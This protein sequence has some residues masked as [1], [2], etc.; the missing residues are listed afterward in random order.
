MITTKQIMQIM[1]C[2]H[3]AVAHKMGMLGIQPI[4]K[5]FGHGMRN[6]YPV[7]EEQLRQRMEEKKEISPAERVKQQGHSLGILERCFSRK[8]SAIGMSLSKLRL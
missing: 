5:S 3:G 7:T 6:L 2:S 8:G 4:R 1:Q